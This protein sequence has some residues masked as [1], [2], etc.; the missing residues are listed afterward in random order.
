MVETI[1]GVMTCSKNGCE[2]IMC[3]RYADDIGYICYEC[4][5][6]LKDHQK[7]NPGI[8]ID[9]IRNICYMVRIY[10]FFFYKHYNSSNS[11]SN[12]IIG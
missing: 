3:S 10:I 5:S 6:D 11:F 7:H 9:G 12:A 2:N 1:M 4:F 8:D